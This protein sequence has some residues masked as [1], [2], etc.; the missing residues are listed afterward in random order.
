MKLFHYNIADSLEGE[1][2][3]GNSELAA[4]EAI[5]TELENREC[6]L[7]GTINVEIRE[8][9]NP[10]PVTIVVRRKVSFEIISDPINFG[11]S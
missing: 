11:T 9:G 6:L 8:D 10:K 5:L 4:N 3:A 7:S 2:Y 1:V